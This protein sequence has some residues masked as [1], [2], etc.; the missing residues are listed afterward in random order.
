[1][2]VN[3]TVYHTVLYIHN[4]SPPD[5]AGC[6]SIFASPRKLG[7][8]A[9]YTLHII[10]P[11]TVN[12]LD[13]TTHTLPNAHTHLNLSLPL[14]PLPLHTPPDSIHPTPLPSDNW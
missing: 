13:S 12:S 1:M 6:L 7:N 2:E 8:D 14:S 4:L 11:L 10:H 9:L 3:I 5:E